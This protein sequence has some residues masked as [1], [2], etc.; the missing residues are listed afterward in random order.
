VRCLLVSCLIAAGCHARPV[1]SEPGCGDAIIPPSILR[2]KVDLLF[3]V[4]DA[5]SMAPKIAALQ[6]GVPALLA[7]LDAGEQPAS[8]HFGV[9]TADLGAPAFGCHAGGDHGALRDAGGSGGVR[10]IDDNRIA[11]T[12][13]VSDVGGALA[14]LVDVPASG[15]AIR[16]P[17]EAAYRALHDQVPENAGFLR[18][19]AVLAVVFVSDADDCSAPVTTDLFDASATQYGPLTRFRCTQFGIE[20]NGMPLPAPPLSPQGG[21][22]PR[23]PMDG[24]QLLDVQKYVDFFK[25]PAAQGGVKVDPDDVILAGMTGPSD[26]VAV[27]LDSPC[28]EDA[29]A[30]ECAVLNHSCISPTNPL[31]AGDPAVRL[32]AVISAARHDNLSSICDTDDSSAL[33]AV[34]NLIASRLGGGCLQQPV[35]TRADGT[36]DCTVNDVTANPDGS[37]TTTAIPSC[38]F[39]APPCWRSVDE[40]AAYDAEGC[41][42]P[43]PP[44]CTLPSTCQPVVNPVDGKRQ[45]YRII[46]DRNGA[47]A[48][49]AT[50]PNVICRSP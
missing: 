1:A 41:T 9:V 12:S 29:S 24:G 17:L 14:A 8:Y 15:C 16:Q 34:G 6:A 22:T 50:T 27:R 45:L 44:T 38:S 7:A 46:V 49:A 2:N 31:F 25:R 26:P 20:C 47:P 19:D 48:P 21:C 33:R 37:T 32:D 35:A 10:Y 40:L 11:G 43:S 28:S 5:P 23:S 30:T 39:S 13:N 42:P 18:S 36:P 3:V 4:D